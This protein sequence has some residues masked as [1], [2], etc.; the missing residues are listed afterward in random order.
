MAID[1]QDGDYTLL[2]EAADKLDAA[3][4]SEQDCLA[5]LCDLSG[6]GSWEEIGGQSVYTAL[7]SAETTNHPNEQ[8]AVSVDTYT[9]GDEL[10]PTRVAR[11]FGVDEVNVCKSAG[12]ILQGED[13]IGRHIF[14]TLPGENGEVVISATT[15]REMVSQ[16]GEEDEDDYWKPFKWSQ[17]QTVVDASGGQ[18]E[19]FKLLAAILRRFGDAKLQE[20]TFIPYGI[21]FSDSDFI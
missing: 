11:R 18:S 7:C 15:V 4:D 13:L 8:D 3:A 19:R 2:F 9:P 17:L 16:N 12:Y 5:T 10:I 6:V 1:Y 14:Q 20:E 21:Q